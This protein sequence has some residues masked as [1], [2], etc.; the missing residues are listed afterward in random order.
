MAAPDCYKC[1]FRDSR[2]K[3]AWK[4]CSQDSSGIGTNQAW[5]LAAQ[6]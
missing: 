2:Q 6:K 3:N 1:S 4:K 5:V